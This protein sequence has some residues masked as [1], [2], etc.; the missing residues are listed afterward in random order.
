M[1][2]GGIKSSI[3][4]SVRRSVGVMGPRGLPAAMAG[5]GEGGG[6]RLN[7]LSVYH[8]HTV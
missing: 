1:G 3:R 4:L 6:A 5:G 7:R 2:G 8:T